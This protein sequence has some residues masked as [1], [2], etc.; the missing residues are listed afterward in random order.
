METQNA[1]WAMGVCRAGAA[2][3]F[4]VVAYGLPGRASGISEAKGIYRRYYKAEGWMKGKTQG[5][6]KFFLG[7]SGVP[8]YPLRHCLQMSL[9]TK[10]GKKMAVS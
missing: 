10:L 7:L 1:P 4:P 6:N 2:K 3:Q 9:S 5:L 8:V